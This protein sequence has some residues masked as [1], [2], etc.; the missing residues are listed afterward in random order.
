VVERYLAKVDVAS[1]SLVSRLVSIVSNRKYLSR[2]ESLDLAPPSRGILLLRNPRS[3][4]E[5]HRTV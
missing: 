3:Q 5:G 2:L 4:R 1:S